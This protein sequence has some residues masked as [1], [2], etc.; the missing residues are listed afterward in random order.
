MRPAPRCRISDLADTDLRHYSFVRNSGLRRADFGLP[1]SDDLG[2]RIVFGLCIVIIF[3]LVIFFV[4][5]GK[6]FNWLA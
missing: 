4:T 3:S 1:E 6:F 5:G 2:D